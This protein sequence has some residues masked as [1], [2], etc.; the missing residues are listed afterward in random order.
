MSCYRALGVIHKGRPRK[1]GVKS[2][3]LRTGGRG[4]EGKW[5]RPQKK[6]KLPN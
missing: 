6:F 3:R 4:F 2:G 5:G 1:G